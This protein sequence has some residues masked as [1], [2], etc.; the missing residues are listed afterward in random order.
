MT[1]LKVG[2]IGFLIATTVTGA[3]AGPN[4]LV[5]SIAHERMV[6]GWRSSEPRCGWTV[7]GYTC[8][9]RTAMR[10]SHHYRAKN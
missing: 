1:A 5:W 3:S 2:L 9:P 4:Y 8:S 6:M 7:S 10:S